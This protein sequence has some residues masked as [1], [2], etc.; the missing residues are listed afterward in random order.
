GGAGIGRGGGRGGGGGGGAA[1]ESGLY[2]SDDAGQTWRRVST[3]NPRPL[4]FSQVRVDPNNADRV[5]MGGVKMQMTI[6]AGKTM[7]TSASL[8]AH[9]DVHAIWFD[10]ANSDH[11]MIGDDGG[12]SASYDGAK[13]WNFSANLPAGLFYHLGY[14]MQ[15]P[16]NI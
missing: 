11:I 9:D 1:G 12:V 13:T 10:P 3:T 14:D 5:L 4:Y 8:A 7:E 6:D 16:F 15:V 2:R